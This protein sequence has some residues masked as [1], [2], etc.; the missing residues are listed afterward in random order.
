MGPTAPAPLGDLSGLDADSLVNFG[1][2]QTP[3]STLLAMGRQD[4]D[5][6]LVAA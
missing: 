3:I 4:C 2:M 5:R 1:G 6:L